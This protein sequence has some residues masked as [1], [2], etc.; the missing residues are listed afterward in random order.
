MSRSPEFFKTLIMGFV[1]GGI[2]TGMSCAVVP[3]T[4]LMNTSLS[5]SI[6]NAL[7]NHEVLTKNLPVLNLVN[8]CKLKAFYSFVSLKK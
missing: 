7:K 8:Q 4:R 5:L 1:G 6:D 3:T 2:N